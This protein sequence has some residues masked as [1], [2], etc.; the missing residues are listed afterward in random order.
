PVGDPL[1]DLGEELVDEDVRGHLLQ[2]TSM[3]VDE[4]DIAAARD[5]EVGVAAFSRAVYGTAEHRHL[6]M[7]WV[8]RKPFLHLFRE[9]VDADVVATARRARDHHRAALAQA[10][11]LE[12][13]VRRLRLLDRIRGE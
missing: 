5:P 13:L 10:E 7:L 9:R 2:D 11:R 8:L 12:D 6:E 1:V 3:R 4:A